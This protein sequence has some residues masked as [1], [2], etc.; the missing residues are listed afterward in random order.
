M[1][2]NT[3]DENLSFKIQKI[4]HVVN[5]EI[6]SRSNK[7]SRKAMTMKESTRSIISLNRIKNDELIRLA[8]K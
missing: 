6:L 8:N 4:L 5:N 7:L 3:R 2:L 1:K